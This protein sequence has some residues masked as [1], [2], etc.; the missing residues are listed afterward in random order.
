VYISEDP[1]IVYRGKAEVTRNCDK[2]QLRACFKKLDFISDK[3]TQIRQ[4][5]A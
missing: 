4:P 5:L 3:R 1:R 2:Y